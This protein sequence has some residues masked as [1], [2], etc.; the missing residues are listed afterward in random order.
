MDRIIGIID[1]NYLTDEHMASIEKLGKELG[2][3]ILMLTKDYEGLEHCEVL[4]GKPEGSLLKQ[5]KNLRWYQCAFAG[6]ETVKEPS[7]YA[8]EDVILTN[9]AGAFGIT[10]S[11]HMIATL[12]MLMRNLPQYILFQQNSEWKRLVKIRSI[13]GSRIT[14]VGLGDIG[15]NFAQRAHA[16]GARITA[17]RRSEQPKPEYIERQFLWTELDEGIKE[18]EVVALCLPSTAETQH[19]IDKR[20]L[21]L[22][23][24]DTL[25]LNVGRGTA[26]DQEA[27]C[28]ALNE[29]RIGGAALDVMVPEPLPKTHPLWTAKN[30]ILTPHV[31]GDTSL[32]HTCN[33]IVEIFLEN[34]RLYAEGKPMKHV[35]DRQKGY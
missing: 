28:E 25:L 15:S 18:A 31:S 12:L 32:I 4:F 26:L 1:N 3:K 21:D 5:A 24:P 23:R 35:V 13:Y 30:C 16:L 17:V 33:L 10:V 34:L 22:L 20:R 6:V 8:S 27:L 7:L 9:A 14:V 19:I 11:E 29:G 2:F